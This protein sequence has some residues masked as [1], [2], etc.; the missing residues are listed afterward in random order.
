MSKNN[1]A[2]ITHTPYSNYLLF[3]GFFWDV[4]E[5]SCDLVRLRPASC[6]AGNEHCEAPTKLDGSPLLGTTL[7]QNRLAFAESLC[8]H[9]TPWYTIILYQVFSHSYHVSL[10][11][12]SINSSANTLINDAWL[13]KKIRQIK[14]RRRQPSLAR[15]I[16]RLQWQYRQRYCLVNRTTSLYWVPSDMACQT[17][18]RLLWRVDQVIRLPAGAKLCVESPYVWGQYKKASACILIRKIRDSTTAGTPKNTS[19]VRSH[20]QL[21]LLHFFH[22]LPSPTCKHPSS[23][24]LDLSRCSID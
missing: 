14:S 12:L 20:Q 5:Y 3:F 16:W 6:I 17:E 15:R 13:W 8:L 10:C 11:F 18:Q 1:N 7:Q 24:H 19:M 4:P 23:C 9:W 22:L 21:L 2:V